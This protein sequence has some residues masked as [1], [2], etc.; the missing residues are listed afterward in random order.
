MTAAASVP[1]HAGC[2]VICLVWTALVLGAGRG[3]MALLLAAACGSAALWAAAVALAPDAPGVGLA[4]ALDVLRTLVWFAL[5]LALCRRTGGARARTLVRRFALAGGAVAAAD[6]LLLLDAGP[7]GAG[8]LVVPTLGSPGLLLRLALALLVVLLAENLYRN[9]GE[10]SRWYVNL[11]AIALGGLAAF[12]VLLYADAALARAFSPVLIDTRAALTALATPLL[13]VT[14][15]RDRRWRRNSPVSRQVVFHGATLVIAGAFLLGVGAVGEVF[16]RVDA[17]WGPAAQTSLLAGAVM[18]LAV[19]ASSGTVRSRLRNTVVDHFFTARYDYRREWLRCINTLSILGE[20]TP[21]ALRAVRAV[22][23]PADSP[24]GVLLLREPGEAGF[25]WAGSWN[26]PAEPV[27]LPG[28]HPLAGLLRDGAWVAT[29]RLDAEAATGG[30]PRAAQGAGAA[31][32]HGAGRFAPLGGELPAPPRGELP[33]PLR[34]EPPAPLRGDAPSLA[35]VPAELR[36]AYGPLW[37]AVPLVHHR[38]G[39]LGAV[40]LAPPRAAF[41]LDR[42]VFDLLRTLGREVA[43]FLAERR[44]AE[45][46]AEARELQDYAKRFAFVAHDVKTVSSQLTLLLANAADNI[47]DPEFQQDMLLP[48]GASASRINALIARLGQPGDAPSPPP[49]AAAGH[50]RDGDAAPAGAL[51]RLRALAARRADRARL[52]VEADV[53][54]E[55][56]PAPVAMEPEKF[57]AAATHLINNAVEASAPGQPIRVR[58]R[59]EA[60]QVVVDI[61]DEGAG[62]TAEFVR[63][64]LFRPLSTSKP[65]GSGIGA[66]QAREL[67]R[68]AGGDLVA[69]SRPGRGTTMRLLLPRAGIGAAEAGRREPAVAAPGGRA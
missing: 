54:A 10:T 46:L 59:H 28:G 31:A 27:A 51:A 13:A 58:V 11:P 52:A 8:A 17:G 5:L 32:P 44:A 68:E 30:D 57:D 43:M 67:L 66:W 24:A 23:D 49:A 33:A 53:A 56:D 25:R 65:G 22:A 19:A 3:R 45:R 9:A 40:L 38:E 60:G 7:G 47:G 39:L 12:D 4:G 18:A 1:L 16:R 37:L 61:V 69:I 64:A 20:E 50:G 14:A 21:A 41:A 2:A 29:F 6:F 55:R 48:V 63:D 35:E 42:E 34:G 36:A 15:V 62:M 26:L